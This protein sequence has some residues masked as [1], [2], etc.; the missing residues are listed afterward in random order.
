MT[1]RRTLDLVR[2]VRAA[3][4]TPIVLF[5]YANPV[6]RM[7]PRAFARAAAD[8]GV[9]GVLILDYPVEEAEPLRAPAGRRRAR[10]D[11][12]GQPDHHRRAHPPLRRARSRLSL[13]HLAAGRDRHARPAGGG[14]AGAAR[15]GPG[16]VAAADRASGSASRA[17]STSPR[18]AARP[19]RRSSA[20]RWST[21][22][23]A[24]TTATPATRASEYVQ[25]AEER[26]VELIESLRQAHRRARRTAGAPALR[27]RGL[28]ARSRPRQEGGRA[29]Q[30]YQPTREAEVLAHVAQ[31]QSRTARRRRHPAP[32]RAH[33]RRGPAARAHRRRRGQTR[34]NP[35]N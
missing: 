10:S 26:P 6:L 28:R 22:S 13:R 14:R 20:A 23:R 24:V 16:R 11:L 19:T 29:S 8:A 3:V 30:I 5:T 27:A 7:E 32:V 9:D 4:D 2:D 35:L 17:R 31:R 1:L 15:A 21:P 34:A 12:P 18:R 25:V 33:H